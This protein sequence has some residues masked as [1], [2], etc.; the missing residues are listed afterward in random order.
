MVNA[1]AKQKLSNKERAEL[2]MPLLG[3]P[4]VQVA[5]GK[6]ILS[7]GLYEDQWEWLKAYGNNAVPKMEGAVVQRMAIQ[8]FIDATEASRVGVVATPE[9]DRD[10]EKLSQAKVRKNKKS[11]EN[12]ITRRK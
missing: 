1:K 7:N 11:V 6:Q 8:W 10:F 9:Q 5:E 4:P 2:G 3:K 12:K